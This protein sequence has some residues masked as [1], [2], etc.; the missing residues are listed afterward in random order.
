[1]NSRYLKELEAIANMKRCG[2]SKI[3]MSH[4]SSPSFEK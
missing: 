4:I 3:I 2:G 1:M